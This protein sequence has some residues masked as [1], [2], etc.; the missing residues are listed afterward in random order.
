MML[1]MMLMSG[2]ELGGGSPSQ[3]RGTQWH[4]IHTRCMVKTHRCVP[5]SLMGCL[6][7]LPIP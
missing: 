4:I 3:V 2:M 7:S 6:L 1:M 5:L